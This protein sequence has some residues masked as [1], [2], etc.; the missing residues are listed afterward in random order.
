MKTLDNTTKH[1]L[2]IKLKDELFAV[3]V[4]KVLEVLQN[5]HI[6]NVPNVPDFIKG[7]I[8]FRGEILPVIEARQKFNM[9]NRGEDEKHVII[10]L[11]LIVNDK[12][13]MLGV[14]ADGVK[15]VLEISEN[16]ILDVPE[17]GSNYNTEFLNGM[18]KLEEGFL[19]LLNVDKVFSAEEINIISTSELS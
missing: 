15:D 1:F 7:V 13:I 17:M 11:D 10:V 9:S 14:M 4:K 3:N 16:E 18:V 19:M 2:S 6:T 8:N 5:Q 12:K